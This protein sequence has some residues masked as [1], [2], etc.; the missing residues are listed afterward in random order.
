MTQQKS[1]GR[2]VPEGRRKAV[3]TRPREGGKAIPV[4]EA[5]PQLSMGFATAEIPRQRGA[6]G[7]ARADRSARTT[8][9]VPKAKDTRRQVVPATMEKVVEQLAAAL[10]KVVANKGASGPDRQ[11]VDEVREHWPTIHRTLSAALLEGSYLPGEIRRVWIPKAGGGQRGLGIPNVVDRVVQEAVRSVLEPMYEPT[12]HASSHGFRPNR[13]CHTA[14]AE[15]CSHVREGF[16][17]VVDIDLEK[18]FDRVHHQR[19]LSRLAER[20][21]DSRLLAL[22]GRMLKAAV[23]MPE[24]V[25]VHTEEGVPQ[26][27]PL[28]PLLSNIVL[29]ELDE[30]AAPEARVEAHASWLTGVFEALAPDGALVIVEPA[31]RDR[32]RHLQLLRDAL[33]NEGIVPFAPCLH[34]APCPMLTREDDWCHEDLAVDLPAWLVPVARA[35][36]LRHEGLSFSYLVLRKD[37][38][39]LRDVLPAA[40]VRVVSDLMRSKGKLEAHV[41][42]ALAGAPDRIKLRRLDRHLTEANAAWDRIRRGD[43]LALPPLEGERLEADIQVDLVEA[44]S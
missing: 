32:T 9:K 40:R 11:T 19:L 16:A 37:K 14:I 23:V 1:E 4:E 20:V 31:L 10:D 28:S 18:F 34:A 5:E 3:P 7:M 41:C 24:G 6:E 13:S 26:G 8:Q 15:A 35:A 30:N 43:L 33:A 22:I 38:K 27:G 17:W 29:S 39:S 2:V 42:G 44:R 12:F 25:R 36:G 21:T